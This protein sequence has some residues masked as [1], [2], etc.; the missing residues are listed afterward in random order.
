[1]TNQAEIEAL[2][3]QI[4]MNE[5][6]QRELTDKLFKMKVGEIKAVSIPCHDCNGT[7]EFVRSSWDRDDGPESCEWC[8]GT[9]YESAPL[10]EGKR[11]YGAEIELLEGLR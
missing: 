1:M 3:A 9:G 6:K 8:S 10:F 5:D 2:E 4:A 11:D 7:G